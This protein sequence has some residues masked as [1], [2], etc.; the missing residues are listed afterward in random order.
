M[1][2]NGIQVDWTDDE[3][4][5]LQEVKANRVVKETLDARAAITLS[6]SLKDKVQQYA[7]ARGM[8][9]SEV[10]RQVLHVFIQ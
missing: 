3:W 8:T 5:R 4:E 2:Y 10:I 9:L 1:D 7:D 6:A